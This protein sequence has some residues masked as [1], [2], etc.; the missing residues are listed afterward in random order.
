MWN[1]VWPDANLTLDLKGHFGGNKGQ[2]SGKK[3]YNSL[4]A[5]TEDVQVC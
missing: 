4:Y 5:I 2:M 3:S 1:R